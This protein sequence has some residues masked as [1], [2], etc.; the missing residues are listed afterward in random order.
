MDKTIVRC[1]SPE[2]G[3]PATH[4]IAATWRDGRFAE[5]KTYG[6]ACPAHVAEVCRQTEIRWL[7]YEPVP[8]EK[9]GGI[10]IYQY[11]PGK[12]DRQFVRDRALEEE[13]LTCPPPN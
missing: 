3:E 4:K 2:C 6:F 7:D 12:T 9:V 8:G 10:A 5:L 13:I 1:D 11:E